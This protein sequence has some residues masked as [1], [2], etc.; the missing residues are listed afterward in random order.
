MPLPISRLLSLAPIL[1]SVLTMPVAAQQ[2][3]QP[4]RTAQA[5]LVWQKGSLE[6]SEAFGRIGPAALHSKFIAVADDASKEILLYT[7]AGRLQAR[8]GR[9]GTGPGEFRSITDLTFSGDTLLVVDKGQNRVSAFLEGR[10]LFSRTL[11]RGNRR[12]V[13]ENVVAALP[14]G[15]FLFALRPA[16]RESLEMNVGTIQHFNYGPTNDSNWKVG[17]VEP[18]RLAVKV[19]AQGQDQ[20]IVA[21]HL[22]NIA[23]GSEV[24]VSSNGRYWALANADF[25]KSSIDFEFTDLER[26]TRTRVTV[27]FKP[28]RTR[29]AQIDS[30]AEDLAR[31]VVQMRPTT[32][33]VRSAIL[34]QIKPAW[35]SPVLALAASNT[36]EVWFR[37]NARENLWTKLTSG[38]AGVRVRLQPGDEIIAADGEMIVTRV[39]YLDGVPVLRLYRVR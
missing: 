3:T 20:F 1:G 18:P 25:E 27:P 10:V 39:R 30:I 19:N 35:E 24:A 28:T 23:I 16:T 26:Q 34:E 11:P 33:A 2:T 38:G 9:S 8:F 37:E 6:G 14:G 29:D 7:H 4:M 31:S 12:D 17:E 5:T 21:P 32:R 15:R 36:G 22:R 13:F